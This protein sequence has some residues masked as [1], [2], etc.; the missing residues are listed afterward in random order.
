MLLPLKPARLVMTGLA[1][2]GG[3]ETGYLTF[4]HLTSTPVS[5]AFCTNAHACSEVL[6]GPF[7]VFPG[8]EIPI[9]SIGMVAYGTVA[10]LSFLNRRN[11]NETQGSLLLFLT[12]AMAAFSGYFVILLSTVL[13][14]S[15]N[16]CLLSAGLS[17]TLFLLTWLDK[18]FVTNRTKAFTISTVSA[19]MTSLLGAFLF[20]LTT[21]LSGAD[22][23][24]ASTAPAAQ[25]L[26]AQ[27][28]DDHRP[29]PITK[30]SSQEALALADQLKSLD[31]HFYGA[32][33]CSHCYNQKQELGMEA[34]AKLPYIE[35]DKEGVDSQYALCRVKKIPGYP[36]WEIK[37]ELYP[38]EKTIKELEALAQKVTQ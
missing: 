11:V 35:C 9:A 23:A 17:F 4:S 3:L 37:G 6:N 10:V 14:Q 12:S 16:Y 36:T 15:C 25:A 38:G 24:N 33:W 28:I 21:T 34:M 13:H 5:Q 18:H 22:I 31:S 2:L 20:Y 8:S 19:S 32:Y 30:H 7:S 26:A 29:P 27:A 1:S